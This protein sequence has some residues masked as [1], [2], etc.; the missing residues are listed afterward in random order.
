M[1]LFLAPSHSLFD[2]ANAED[3]VLATIRQA[4][5][6]NMLVEDL[7]AWAGERLASVQVG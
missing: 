6:Q 4:K 5:E 3:D 7:I 1:N 2:A